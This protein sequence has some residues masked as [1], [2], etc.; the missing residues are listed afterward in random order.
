[1][2][3]NAQILHPLLPGAEPSRDASR[4][5]SHVVPREL[6][7][8]WVII[9]V[10]G[11]LS[12]S[13][14]GCYRQQQAQAMADAY[15]LNPAKDLHDLGRV[16]LVELK[17]ASGHED[18]ARAATQALFL[19]LQKKQIFSL[20]RIGRD[21]PAWKTLQDS[22]DSR[23][24]M[25]TLLDMR[26]TLRCNA[27]MVGAVTEYRPYPRLAIGLRMKLID[28]V[29]GRLLWGVEQVWDT[30]DRSVQRRIGAYAR[31]ELRSGGGPAPE[32][33]VMLSSLELIKFAACEVAQTLDAG[34]R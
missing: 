31:S 14:S 6:R 25:Q 30:T 20:S 24:T 4:H 3:S 28:L 33:L 7:N 18:I 27:L 12:V 1:M 8:R 13:L 10:V 16:A 2:P 17:D 22:L 26:Q 32:E 11:L 9:A 34:K 15:Y 21:D 19:E 23:F 29:D 5:T